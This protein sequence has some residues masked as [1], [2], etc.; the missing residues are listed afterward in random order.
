VSEDRLEG[1]MLITCE[2][3]VPVNSD[4]VIKIFGIFIYIKEYF[5]V[6]SPF[7]LIQ[8][9]IAHTLTLLKRNKNKIGYSKM[10]IY[11]KYQ[12]K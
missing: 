4:D 1:L 5:I 12:N 7:R 10:Y 6:L 9:S 8:L 11:Y 2:R 3:D